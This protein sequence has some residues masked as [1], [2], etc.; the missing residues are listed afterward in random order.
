MLTYSALKAAA[1]SVLLYLSD[2]NC[3][4]LELAIELASKGFATWQTYLDP[5]NLLRLLFRL[6]TQTP[7]S[8]SISAQARLAVLHVASL[9]PALF[10]STLSMDIQ[11]A[12]TVEGRTSIMK[13][14]VFM[15]R[16][17]PAVLQNGLPRIAES[18][19]RSLDPNVGKMRD[20]VQEAATVILNE[21]V[22][23]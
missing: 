9:N 5:I 2:S 12:R 22:L 17:R 10:M 21:L 13:L 18:V 15:A 4:H 8:P 16:K 19:V 6:S 20:D 1:D 3:I 11:D 14:C 7:P 23:A